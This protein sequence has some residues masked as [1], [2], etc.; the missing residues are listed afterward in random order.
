MV[1]CA[2]FN[3]RKA[4]RAVTQF[5]EKIMEPTDLR[6]TQF[7]LLTVMAIAGS[8][9]ISKLAEMLVMDRTTL[10]RELRTLKRK[11][12]VKVTAGEDRRQ[13]IAALTARGHQVVKEAYPLW[14][15][16]QTRMVGLLGERRW[17]RLLSEISEITALVQQ[18]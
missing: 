17:K 14:E 18:N 2:C 13:R 5:Y 11:G 8:T 1:A 6:A 9:T 16:A 7:T 15:K 3:F 12:L 10:T 4:S